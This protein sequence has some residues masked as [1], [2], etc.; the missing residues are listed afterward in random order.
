MNRAIPSHIAA[1]AVDA[2]HMELPNGCR[3]A[4]GRYN[5]GNGYSTYRGH[6]A[7][8]AAWTGVH[9]PIPDGLV[10]DHL[11]FT[12]TCV[13]V[14]HLRVISLGENSQRRWG[15]RFPLGQCAAGHPRSMIT[16]YHFPSGDQ[17]MCSECYRVR[18]YASSARRNAL[19]RLERIY[20]LRLT[21][22]QQ[23]M[24]DEFLPASIRSDTPEE[25]Q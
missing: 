20:G 9:G 19:Q 5:E 6:L 17:R 15:A 22:R 21:D 13:N 3:P 4:A 11:C 18:N 24:V 2:W 1:E 12:R 10:V 25:G 7:H 8:R 16:V 14:D 23:A